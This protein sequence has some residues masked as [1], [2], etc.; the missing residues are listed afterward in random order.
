MKQ[1]RFIIMAISLAAAAS[2]YGATI[3]AVDFGGAA[4]PV[5]SGF[6]GQSGS[7]ATHSTSGGNITVAI[8]GQQGIQGLTALTSAVEGYN[9]YND[10][11]FKNGGS[12]TLTI[13]GPGIAANTEYEMTFWSIY[14]NIQT[15][16]TSFVATSGTTGTTLGPIATA[17]TTP[18]GFDDP[19]YSAT[20]T[21]TSDSSG[22]LT[23]A[24]NGVGSGSTNRPMVNG[25]QIA[26]IPEPSSA[27]L[28][29][30]LG[31]LALLRRR[32]R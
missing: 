25:F 26:S 8:A 9:M 31:G 30:G 21:F 6:V 27:A 22:V 13:S 18:T 10:G 20:G 3:L 24:I 23:F 28:L 16:T 11:A 5:Q 2:S 1:T 15:R 32:R 29:G 14:Y 17:I 7:S 12:M 4:S 19:A